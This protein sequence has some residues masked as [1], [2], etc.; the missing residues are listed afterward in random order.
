MVFRLIGKYLINEFFV[1]KIEG[2]IFLRF[3]I[4]AK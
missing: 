2:L 4:A 3:K 1:N